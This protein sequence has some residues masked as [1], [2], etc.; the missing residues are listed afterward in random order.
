MA[1]TVYIPTPFRRATGNRDRVESSAPDVGAVL[2]ELERVYS[3]LKGLV[4]NEQGEVHRHVNIYVNGD[5]IDDAKGL[6]TS[7]KDG[8][9]VEH[10]P[11]ARGGGAVAPERAWRRGP[12]PEVA[13]DPHARGERAH[14]DP[15]G[16]GVSGGVV[17]RH[18]HARHR[19]PAPAVPQR[20]GRAARARP[21]K[22]PRT[23]R[24]AYYIDSEDL[25]R[26]A[27]SRRKASSWRSSITRTWT[28]ARISRRPTG[29]MPRRE[30]CRCTRMRPTW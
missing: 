21:A 4:R 5:A 16:G 14:P 11:G 28:P 22:H 23:A 26:I 30:A 10:H 20:A 8:D 24:T 6:G 2:D 3:G 25:L 15:G 13:R 12:P 7:L 17:R 19:A 9:E 18:P 1:V 27:I 29:A